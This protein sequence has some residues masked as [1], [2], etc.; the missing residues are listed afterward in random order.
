MAARKSP[1]HQGE[2]EQVAWDQAFFDPIPLPGG[3]PLVTLR[4]AGNY[5]AALPESEQRLAHWRNA[6]E[7]LLLVAESNGDPMFARI[8]MMQALHHGK[9]APAKP[10]GRKRARAYRII[11]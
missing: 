6:T 1:P 2:G 5:I 8:G 4:D 10:P 7:A 9:P 11:R 3:A